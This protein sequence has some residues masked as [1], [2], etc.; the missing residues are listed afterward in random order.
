MM[1]IIG[2]SFARALGASF[3][4]LLLV[5][6]DRMIER[7]PRA[8]MLDTVSAGPQFPAEYVNHL[9]AAYQVQFEQREVGQHIC[10]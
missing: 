5:F 7:K 9:L 6:L 10:R 8:M 1:I 2:N 3:L 4:C